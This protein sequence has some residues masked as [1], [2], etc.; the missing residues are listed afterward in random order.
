M[1]R[2][3]S[4]TKTSFCFQTLHHLRRGM[5]KSGRSVFVQSVPD[6]GPQICQ[7]PREAI[8]VIGIKVRAWKPEGSG[9]T[10][11]CAADDIKFFD[12]QDRHAFKRSGQSG[13]QSARPGTE[14]KQVNLL[15]KP[16]HTETLNRACRDRIG[17]V[18]AKRSKLA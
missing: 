15:R 11:G 3:G 2:I 1:V 13:R 17:Q 6:S 12:Q 9:R 4:Q 18:C 8:I 10:G 5:Q 7:S 14:N 16:C